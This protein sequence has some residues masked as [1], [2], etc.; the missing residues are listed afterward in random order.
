MYIEDEEVAKEAFKVIGEYIK[1]NTF[2][3]N[4]DDI[5]KI[6]KKCYTSRK[7]KLSS[8]TYNILLRVSKTLKDKRSHDYYDA[9]E[10]TKKSDE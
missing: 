3:E 5:V 2:V 10:Q 6:I 1:D 9:E 8:T 7:E 4:A